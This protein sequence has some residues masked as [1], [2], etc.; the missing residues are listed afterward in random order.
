MK[1]IYIIGSKG[2]PS[3]YGGFETFVEKLTT[4]T[5]NKNFRYHVS[6][7]SDNYDITSYKGVECFNVP[8]PKLG[9][10][11][12]ILHVSNSLKLVYKSIK[13]DHI[14]SST[15]LILGC[16]IGPLMGYHYRKLKKLNTKVIVNPDGLEWKRAK[17]NFVEKRFI[18]FCEKCLI[19][20]SD[21][22]VCDS[23]EIK[24]IMI[25]CFKVSESKATYI[26]YGADMVEGDS[27]QEIDKLNSWYKSHDIIKG[28][29]YLV[30]G[31]FV[32][33]N[34]YELIYF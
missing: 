29:Y 18:R 16:R 2:I 28:D 33:E 14:K 12:R 11:G 22:V 5:T 17:W 31:R 30:V 1:D 4:L 26:A 6:C 19:K 25:E 10:I 34:N 23:E 24:R 3:N 7:M 20:N 13:K 8:V 15:V 32:P 21:L 27:E 9:A